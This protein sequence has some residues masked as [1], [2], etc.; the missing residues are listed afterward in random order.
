MKGQPGREVRPAE[1]AQRW[2]ERWFG[3]GPKTPPETSL[4]KMEPGE[5]FRLAE[6]AQK[7]RD[8]AEIFRRGFKQGD[9]DVPYL[10]E[11]LQA[12]FDA[13]LRDALDA[14]ASLRS[15]GNRE[16]SSEALRSWLGNLPLQ[17]AVHIKLGYAEEL[18]R[19]KDLRGQSWGEMRGE[20]ELR[21]A[22]TNR[23]LKSIVD[24]QNHFEKLHPWIV[25]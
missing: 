16:I 17:Q 23:V 8:E 25:P 3:S 7:M 14:L 5:I 20:P 1:L 10:R 13:Y 9:K 4:K 6:L 22:A 11:D 21:D 2:W 18:L 19:L 24:L 12:E 15:E